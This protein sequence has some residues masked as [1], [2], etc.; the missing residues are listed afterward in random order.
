MVLIKETP[1]NTRICIDPTQ[2]FNKGILRPLYQMPTLS[3]QVHKLCHAKCFSLVDVRKGFLH[4]P[5]DEES[6][7]MTT[8]VRVIWEKPMAPSP[9]CI[10]GAPEEFQ[11]RLMSALEGLDGV[12]CNV[13][14]ILVFG[15]GS[16]YQE[17]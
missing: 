6:S 1:K 8:I 7:L 17:A 15:E 11:K 5:R 9:I 16:A 13:H 14:D 4:V 2:T 3:E 12:F 10:S